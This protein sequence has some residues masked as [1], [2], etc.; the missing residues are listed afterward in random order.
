MHSLCAEEWVLVICEA[1]LSYCLYS[2]AM[3]QHR[4]WICV[5]II[6]DAGEHGFIACSVPKFDQ[7]FSVWL[8]LLNKQYWLQL[9]TRY[10]FAVWCMRLGESKFQVSRRIWILRWMEIAWDSCT[11]CFH[12]FFFTGW[13]D[14]NCTP[15]TS[16]VLFNPQDHPGHLRMSQSWGTCKIIRICYFNHTWD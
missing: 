1:L 2:G 16:C 14:V 7:R 3:R 5:S 9:R 15:L 4:S 13:S 12:R 8:C 6:T 10:W 11:W